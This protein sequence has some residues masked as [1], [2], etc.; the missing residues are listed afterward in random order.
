MPRIP[1]IL[2]DGIYEVDRHPEL[3]KR[4]PKKIN[5]LDPRQLCAW[6]PDHERQQD[7][8][9]SVGS[10]T[11]VAPS[12]MTTSREDVHLWLAIL[13]AMPSWMRGAQGIGDCASWGEEGCLTTL[14]SL[15]HCKG[16]GQFIAPA[17]T[18]AIYGGGR[19]EALGKSRGG[20]QDG[21]FGAAVAKWSRDW[22]AILRVDYSQQ[23][24]NREHDLRKYSAKKAKQ[25]GNFGCGGKDDN[26][27]LDGVARL[28][29]CQHVVGVETVEE[30]VAAIQNLYP[31]T[32][33]SMAGFG[34]M[35]RDRRGVCRIVDRW[36]HL[37][38]VFGLRWRGGEPEFRICQSWGDSCSGPDPGIEDPRIS[39][40]SWWCTAEDM[41]WILR[42][43]DN[44]IHGDLIGLPPQ[45][46]DLVLPASRFY[47]PDVRQSYTLAM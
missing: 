8:R 18:E 30:A 16:Q 40:C 39:A 32:I 36:P 43:G 35:K 26:D 17:A 20:M 31:Y 37:M 24:G 2:D 22:G 6:R 41:A 1:S 34:S 45:T 7:F 27:V 21:A 42:T 38:F 13:E 9:R 33:A 11:Q 14:M 23:T 19:V 44:W 28:M 3:F 12:L 5:G 29:P 47:Q 10:L 4:T 15:M 25:W 46:L